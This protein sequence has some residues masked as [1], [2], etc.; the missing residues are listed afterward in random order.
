MTKRRSSTSRRTCVAALPA[1]GAPFVAVHPF[2]WL[3]WLM[4]AGMA[5]RRP[6]RARG[7]GATGRRVA[8]AAAVEPLVPRR[9]EEA[10]GG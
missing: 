10:A 2:R 3:L 5:S 8:R 7:R 6:P 4:P 1:N 9:R